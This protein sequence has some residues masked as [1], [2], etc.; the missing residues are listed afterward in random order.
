[1]TTGRRLLLMLGGL[2]LVVGAGALVWALSSS[3]A[4][5]ASDVRSFGD[6]P[7]VA[8]PDEIYCTANSQNPDCQEVDS[9]AATIAF[10]LA[11]TYNYAQVGQ[12]FRVT[13][14]SVDSDRDAIVCKP[15]VEGSLRCT[16][17]PTDSMHAGQVAVYWSERD[18]A[19]S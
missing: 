2:A 7:S 9:A 1:M 8:W 19:R 3:R 13:E 16:R 14:L 17:L 11:A 6:P 10:G 15:P 4:D 5:H 12:P 18:S